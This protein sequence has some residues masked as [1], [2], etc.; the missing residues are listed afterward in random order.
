MDLGKI[1]DERRKVKGRAKETERI[2]RGK[3]MENE[4]I[5]LTLEIIDLS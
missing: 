4:T 3:I 1:K 2:P 5:R